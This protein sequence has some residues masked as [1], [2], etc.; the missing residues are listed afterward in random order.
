MR[1]HVEMLDELDGCIIYYGDV[2]RAWFD[3]VFLRVRKKIRQ[4]QLR[5]VIFR[6]PPPNEDK[7]DILRSLGGMVVDSAQA[8]ARLL[9]GD[10][11]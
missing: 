7:T 5:S 11:A 8:A 10:S 3:A 1:T 2:E 6:A 9:L 4:R